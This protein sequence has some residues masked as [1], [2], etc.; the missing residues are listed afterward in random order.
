MIHGLYVS[1]Q[2]ANALSQKLDVISNNLANAQTTGFKHDLAIFQAIQPHDSEFENDGP[3]PGNL[4]QS[5]GGLTLTE[6]ATDFSNGGLQAT[7][8][9]YDLALTGP[10]FFQVNDGNQT[11]LT[12]NGSFTLDQT[13]DLV[14]QDGHRVLNSSG[15][16]INIPLDAAT[17]D[18]GSNGVVYAIDQTGLRVEAGQIDLV[19]PRS[20]HQLTKVGNSYYL[21]AGEVESAL[22]TT[23]IQQG[24]LEGSG[25]NSVSEMMQMIQTSRAFETNIN[26]IKFQDE[27]LGRLLQSGTRV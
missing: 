6:V 22:E 10:G 17:V 4:N 5:T 23:Q 13:G 14:T 26:M 15:G 18:I 24:F 7:G 1:A 16:A 8:G 11:F 27:A 21:V 12:R 9:S 20:A 19:Q 3:V 2:G 25:T